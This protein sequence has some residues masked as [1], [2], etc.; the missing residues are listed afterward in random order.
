[1]IDVKEVLEAAETV[2]VVGCSNQPS[3]T[4]FVISRYLLDRGY[5][6]IPVNPHHAYVHG[7][8]C[9]P[10]LPSIP[11][12]VRVDIVNIFR[13]PRYTAEMLELA[14][15]RVRATGERP[16]IWTQLG[17]SSREAERI[18]H[19]AGLHYVKNRCILVEHGRLLG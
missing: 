10:D 11:A 17:V 9:Y 13:N 14:V 5:R 16:V 15:Q 8:R 12:D 6:V 3:R 2:A 1:M 4:S 19:E 18:A 7:Q